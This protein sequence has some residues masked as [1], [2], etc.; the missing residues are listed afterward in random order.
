MKQKN[1]LPVH[2]RIE[3]EGFAVISHGLV[4]STLPHFS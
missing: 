2:T 3:K 4:A 1:E